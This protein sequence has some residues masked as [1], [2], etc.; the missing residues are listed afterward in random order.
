MAGFAEE[1]EAN[2]ARLL[3]QVGGSGFRAPWILVVGL[4]LFGPFRLIHAHPSCAARLGSQA[5]CGTI[6]RH[7][8]RT[9]FHGWLLHAWYRLCTRWLSQTR[10]QPRRSKVCALDSHGIGRQV[11]AM[12]VAVPAHEGQHHCAGLV[13]HPES[14]PVHLAALRP[15]WILSGVRVCLR[16]A[17]WHPCRLSFRQIVWGW[18]GDRCLR[19]LAYATDARAC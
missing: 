6:S 9:R 1:Q 18:H 7:R 5:Y 17:N 11:F 3:A 2:A 14:V 19:L 12:W 10:A 15:T 16:D 8:G 4:S 13:F